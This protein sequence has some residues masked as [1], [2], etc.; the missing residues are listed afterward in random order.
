MCTGARRGSDGNVGT[1]RGDCVILGGAGGAVTL[2][3]EVVAV[4]GGMTIGSNAPVGESG[5]G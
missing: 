2:G 5:A 3:G 1:L 4:L